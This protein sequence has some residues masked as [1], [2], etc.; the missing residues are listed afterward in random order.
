MQKT[1]V[2][3][4]SIPWE[5][6]ICGHCKEKCSTFLLVYTMW[7]GWKST[8]LSIKM[9]DKVLSLHWWEWTHR[10]RNAH[11]QNEPF[12]AGSDDLLMCWLHTKCSCDRRKF[13]PAGDWGQTP[14]HLEFCFLPYTNIVPLTAWIYCWPIPVS[15]WVLQF[16]PLLIFSCLYFQTGVKGSQ[17]VPAVCIGSAGLSV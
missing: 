2:R 13:C 5:L 10:Q 12:H 6:E 3:L 14:K 7:E 8:W 17:L 9:K 4:V 15:L 11:R 16:K 1:G